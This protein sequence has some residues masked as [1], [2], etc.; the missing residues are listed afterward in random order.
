MNSGIFTVNN[1]SVEEH[2]FYN[3]HF[4]RGN[5]SKHKAR[6]GLVEAGSADFM[7][8]NKKIKVKK[9]DIIFIPEKVFC[10][11]EWSGLPNIE[12][13]YINFTMQNYKA[14]EYGLQVIRS[15][16]GAE[17]LRNI[18]RLLSG[19]AAD[20]FRAYSLLYAFF[21][22]NA[23]KLAKYQ[24][25]F[26]KTLCDAMNFINEN[27]NKD[28]SVQ[29]IARQLTVSES[30]LYHLFQRQLGQTPIE[31]LTSVK[32]NYA[33]KHLEDNGLSIAQIGEKVNFHSES[34]FRRVFKAQVGMSPSAY[35]KKMQ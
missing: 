2:C 13:F 20:E 7:W 8:L 24:N 5:T 22:E 34:Y 1:L 14:G 17:I 18:R 9:G 3:Y 4:C 6:L 11:S 29:D 35:R 23:E 32:I 15:D 16:N 33:M 28:F 12:V 30:S 21:A 27:Y 10:Y 19:S 26:T 31:Y 25:Q